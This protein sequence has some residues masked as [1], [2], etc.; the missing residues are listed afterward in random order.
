[1]AKMAIDSVGPGDNL[2][3]NLPIWSLRMI[4][5]RKL[6]FSR[7]NGHLGGNITDNLFWVKIK[8]INI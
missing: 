3:R 2:A 4:M 7:R 1:M 6:S 5:G 8:T